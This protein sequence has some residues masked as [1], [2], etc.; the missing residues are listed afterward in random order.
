MLRNETI[1][2]INANN[3]TAYLNAVI[4]LSTRFNHTESQAIAVIDK[5]P[6][7]ETSGLANEINLQADRVE[8]IA[9]NLIQD[10]AISAAE[11]IAE[12]RQILVDKSLAQYL[13]RGHFSYVMTLNSVFLKYG[14]P[15]AVMTRL[16]LIGENHQQD[17]E[18]EAEFDRINLQLAVISNRER[19]RLEAIKAKELWD[20]THKLIMDEVGLSE[21]DATMAMSIIPVAEYKSVTHHLQGNTGFCKRFNNYVD[22]L[23]SL[24]QYSYED[25]KE[26]LYKIATEYYFSTPRSVS[27]ALTNNE[28]TTVHKFENWHFTLISEKTCDD[29]HKKY[30]RMYPKK[31]Q[32]ILTDSASNRFSCKPQI[33]LYLPTPPSTATYAVSP[34]IAGHRAAYSVMPKAGAPLLPQANL[35]FN[36]NALYMVSTLSVFGALCLLVSLCPS[37]VI[38]FFKCKKASVKKPNNNIEKSEDTLR[39]A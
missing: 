15:P 10:N 17:D 37:R 39:L 23:M 13:N 28:L 11:A 32:T 9:I 6:A 2:T 33:S 27:S 16:N 18:K 5:F 19:R 25:A 1:N 14:L 20:Y 21:A 36:I 24:S 12:I 38:N 8:S 34:R 31:N 3:N 7:N 4:A 35:S 26:V 30:M 22:K 29:F